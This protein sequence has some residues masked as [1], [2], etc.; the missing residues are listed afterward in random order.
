MVQAGISG[1][2]W[3][4]RD[5]VVLADGRSHEQLLFARSSPAPAASPATAQSSST[6]VYFGRIPRELA[7]RPKEYRFPVEEEKTNEDLLADSKGEVLRETER[8]SVR[9]ASYVCTG[10]SLRVYTD[11]RTCILRAYFRSSARRRLTRIM[12]IL[13]DAPHLLRRTAVNCLP[14][15][16]KMNFSTLAVTSPHANTSLGT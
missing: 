8:S 5:D 11:T 7:A 9:A 2:S 4:F 12:G 10:R 13:A 1:A 3:Y 6:E 15:Q 16:S 14:S